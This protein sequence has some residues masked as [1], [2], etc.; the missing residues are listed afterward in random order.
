VL[1]CQLMEQSLK[2]IAQR[3]SSCPHT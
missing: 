1:I 3:C 2:D